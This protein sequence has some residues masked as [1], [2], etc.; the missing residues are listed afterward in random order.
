MPFIFNLPE[1]NIAEPSTE[2]LLELLLVIFAKSNCIS[3]KL[4]SVAGVNMESTIF[5]SA[6]LVFME[7][8]FICQRGRFAIF[9]KNLLNI[10]AFASTTSGVLAL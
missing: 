8:I 1:S 3:F 6:R 4:C 5:T 2:A 10:F 9:F 7:S